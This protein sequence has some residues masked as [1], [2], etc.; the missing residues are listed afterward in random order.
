MDGS[1]QQSV[2]FVGFFREAGKIM[3][4]RFIHAINYKIYYLLAGP[5]H[6]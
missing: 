5:D 1:K 6:Q 4:T 2:V 3:V